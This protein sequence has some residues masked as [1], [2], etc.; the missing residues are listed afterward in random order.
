MRGHR[1]RHLG[2]GQ[3]LLERQRHRRLEVLAALRRRLRARAPAAGVEDARQDVRER[4]EVG[5]VG[6]AGAAA[7]EGVAG[8]SRQ[9]QPG[10]AV[11]DRRLSAVGHPQRGAGH[12]RRA[13]D[14]R[15]R[16]ARGRVRHHLFFR[17]GRARPGDLQHHPASRSLHPSQGPVRQSD[18]RN[19][20]RPHPLGTPG[21]IS[22]STA[23]N[24]RFT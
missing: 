9:G 19:G 1:H 4:A 8:R 15:D 11:L 23:T 2:A 5:R 16:R 24:S 3:R 7:P 13:S 6:A 12:H 18:H 21:R 17:I 14:H 10:F 22:F 20:F